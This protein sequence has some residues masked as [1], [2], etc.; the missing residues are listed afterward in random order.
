MCNFACTYVSGDQGVDGKGTTFTLIV[1]TQHDQDIFDGN[2]NGE[3][4]DD[5]RQGAEKVVV[6]GCRAKGTRIDVKRTGSNIAVDDTN[7]L[8]GQPEERPAA[9]D[10]L[11]GPFLVNVTNVLRVCRLDILKRPLASDW[12]RVGLVKDSAIKANAIV[13]SHCEQAVHRMVWRVMRQR[14]CQCRRC[15]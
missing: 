7:G 11:F 5:E 4:P 1:G 9:E 15:S 12:R 10:L 14:A 3:S 2:D 8:I 13:V 6:R